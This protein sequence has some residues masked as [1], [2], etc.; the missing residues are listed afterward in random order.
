M[1]FIL[2]DSL[3]FEPGTVDNWK[4]VEDFLRKRSEASTQLQE[5]VHAIWY[6]A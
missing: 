5:R 3:G 1:R 2:H 4:I 6:D